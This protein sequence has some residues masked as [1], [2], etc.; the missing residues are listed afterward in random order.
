MEG[1]PRGHDLCFC[2]L[3]GRPQGHCYSNSISN[4][5]AIDSSASPPRKTWR[6][7]S[8]PVEPRKHH[9]AE[10]TKVD[11]CCS[12]GTEKRCSTG[13]VKRGTQ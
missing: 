7:A 1:L 3:K 6:L 8:G 5:G 12:K 9:A 13:N 10:T 11:R 2:L 4:I